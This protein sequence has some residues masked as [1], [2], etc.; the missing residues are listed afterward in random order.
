[1]ADSESDTEIE[2]LRKREILR[3]QAEWELKEVTAAVLIT[4]GGG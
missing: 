1:M 2:Q 4:H 3:E